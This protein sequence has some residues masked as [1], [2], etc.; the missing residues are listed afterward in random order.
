MLLLYA[1]YQVSE[2]FIDVVTETNSWPIVEATLIP[3]CISS[4]LYSTSVLQNEEL[5]P[6][7]GDICSVISGSN[8][9]MH[10]PRMDKQTMKEYGFLQLP[11]ACHVLAIV[12]D[13]VLSNR[14]TSE[15][16][17]VVVANGCQ[18]DQEFT[19]KLIGDICNLSEQMLLRSSDHRS[20]A[21]RYLLPGIFEAFLSH[22]VLEIIIQGHAC[23]LSRLGLQVF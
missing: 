19:V 21:I 7:E 3:F 18:T 22:N 10:E 9:P 2:S 4:A 16:S 12:L 8:V 17:D 13:A 6:F 23:N 14:Q 20:C 5:D 11:L 1:N 15:I